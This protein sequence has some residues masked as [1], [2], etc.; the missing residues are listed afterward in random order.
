MS[1]RWARAELSVKAHRVLYIHDGMVRTRCGLPAGGFPVQG[2]RITAGAN[3][4]D[5]CPRCNAVAGADV[6]IELLME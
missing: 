4:I 1:D 2:S 5:Q 6:E 3:R